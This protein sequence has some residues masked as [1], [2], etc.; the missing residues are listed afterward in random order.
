MSLPWALWL[1]VFVVHSILFAKGWFASAGLMRIMASTSPVTA[2]ICLYGWNRIAQTQWIQRMPR[3]RHRAVAGAALLTALI[4]AIG[5]YLLYPPNWHT[6]P[7]CQAAHDIQDNHL[8]DGA[9]R[10][11]AADEIVRG[12]IGLPNHAP[13]VLKNIWNKQD[14]LQL[15]SGLPI[16]SVGEWDN[17]RGI[18]F[19][20]IDIPEVLARG[21]VVVYQIDRPSFRW[22]PGAWGWVLRRETE[23]YVIVRKER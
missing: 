11:F 15:L 10:F 8:L 21:Y 3:L 12:E 23:K 14:E 5:N 16:G 2:L 20:Q 22:R 9:P 18:D 1:L 6:F 19:F 17:Q 7:L 13:G 4:W